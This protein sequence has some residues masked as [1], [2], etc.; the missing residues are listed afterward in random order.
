MIDNKFILE[1]KAIASKLTF[2]EETQVKRYM[3]ILGV[4]KGI[5]VNF[6]KELEIKEINL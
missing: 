6:G 2:K 3:K 4:N 5:L 1:L